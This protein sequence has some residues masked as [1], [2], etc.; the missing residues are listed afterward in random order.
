MQKITHKQ[1][2][3]R[4]KR[5]VWPAMVIYL[6]SIFAGSLWLRQ[7]ESAPLWA[8]LLVAM[9]VSVPVA[10][11]MFLLIRYFS[12]T[13]EYNRMLHLRAFAYGASTTISVIFFVGFL[14]MFDVVG[15]VDLILFGLGFLF[16]YPFS[17]W[18]MG[19]KDCV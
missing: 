19:G 10:V 1:A 4:Y 8:G 9:A 5:L 11:V 16:V 12:E 6:A 15:Q 18:L 14:Q 17:Y 13:D 3:K 7:F 2:R